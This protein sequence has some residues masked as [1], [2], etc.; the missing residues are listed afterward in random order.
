MSFREIALTVR[1]V[2]R[3][4]GE[5]QKIGSDAGSLGVQVGRAA[6]GFGA[7]TS[8]VGFLGKEFGVLSAQQSAVIRGAGFLISTA[9]MMVEMNKQGV[10]AETAHIVSLVAH[11]LAEGAAAVAAWF[12]NAALI[13]QVSL[14]TLGIGVAIAIAAAVWG[15]SEAYKAAAANAARFSAA[16]EEQTSVSSGGRSIERSNAYLR[17]GVE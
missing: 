17:R 6:I 9:G 14:M 11:K 3:A 8:A 7:L 5:F 1:C 2:N 10:L 4:S 16:L 12:L 13:V 15:L